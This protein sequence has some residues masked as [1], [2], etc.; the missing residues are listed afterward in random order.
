VVLHGPL[1]HIKL[2]PEIV[3]LAVNHN[4]QFT[5][6]AFDAFNNPVPEA[7][8]T[9]EAVEEAGTISSDGL[10]TAGVNTNIFPDVILASARLNGYSAKASASVTIRPPIIISSN[11]LSYSEDLDKYKVNW[12]LAPRIQLTTSKPVNW[13]AKEPVY[14]TS[15]P[16]YGLLEFREG[17]VIPVAVEDLSEENR[18]VAY[19]DANQNN[20]LS[21]DEPLVAQSGYEPSEGVG[22]TLSYP[23]GECPYS[24]NI[25]HYCETDRLY[26]IRTCLQE[27]TIQIAGKE[28]ILAV[29]DD[30]TDGYYGDPQEALIIDLNGD[31]EADGAHDSDECI[32]LPGMPFYID[33]NPYCLDGV[34]PMGDTVHIAEAE[35]GHLQGIVSDEDTNIPLKGATITLTLPGITLSTTTDSEGRYDFNV[36]AGLYNNIILKYEGYVPKMIYP[37]S[38]LQALVIARETITKDYS[39]KPVGPL[40]GRFTLRDGDV[41]HFLARETSQW[42]PDGDFVV[43]LAGQT[44]VFFVNSNSG[45]QGIHDLGDIGTEPLDQVIIPNSGYR[46]REVEI[47]A[48]HTYVSLAR[49][50]EEGN[51]I[52]FRVIEM[53]EDYITLDYLYLLS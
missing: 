49:Q 36:P 26:Y 48:G 44:P 25:Y 8:I 15:R 17:T 23:E 22:L 19:I 42:W 21:D 18:Y 41:P 11:T 1:H 32:T 27:G 14:L 3:E 53:V 29:L 9:W 12:H 4:R 52:V 51:Y 33:N 39:L 40:S 50:G 43:Q 35:F 47:I 34:T 38:F 45:H 7:Q 13:K 28:Y 16:L 5:I 10:F 37:S 30:H 46:E 24:I 2:N 31:G 6:E 20:D